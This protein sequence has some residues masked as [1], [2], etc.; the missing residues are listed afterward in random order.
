MTRTRTDTPP[1]HGHVK[2]KKNKSSPLSPNY[3]SVSRN[4]SR[5]RGAGFD[6]D[7]FAYTVKLSKKELKMYCHILPHPKLLEVRH[8]NSFLYFFL[9]NVRTKGASFP[10]VKLSF[11]LNL[12]SECNIFVRHQICIRGLNFKKGRYIA[13]SKPKQKLKVNLRKLGWLNLFGWTGPCHV[14]VFVRELVI[15]LKIQSEGSLNQNSC[16][17]ENIKTN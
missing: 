8:A 16:S 15:R 1:W 9:E 11:G 2:P 5:I 12:P 13:I 4:L 6:D 3:T 7:F 14:G 10:V 17:K